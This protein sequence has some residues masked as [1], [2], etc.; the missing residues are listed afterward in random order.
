MTHFLRRLLPRVGSALRAGPG[1][2]RCVA[3]AAL[4]ASCSTTPPPVEVGSLAD[5]PPRY[6]IVVIIHG[7]A[8]YAYHDTLGKVHRS[9]QEILSRARTVGERNAEAEVFIFHQI[10]RRHLLFLIPRRDGRAYVYR[11]GRLVARQSYW[12]DQGASPFDPEVRLYHQLAGTAASPP[13]RQFFYF[14]HELPEI[15]GTGY[16]ASYRKRPVTIDDLAEAVKSIAGNG[17]KIDLLGLAT[18]FG[19]TPHTIRALAPHA[20]YIV[21]SPDNLHLSS[22]DLTPLESLELESDDGAVA[23]FADRFARNAFER[24]ASEVQTVVSV[25]VYDTEDTWAFLDAVTGEYDRTLASTLGRSRSS[26]H[27]CDCADDSAYVLPGMSQGLT[28]LY[29]APRFGRLKGKVG[30]SGWECRRIL[31]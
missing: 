23:A 19:G 25:V 18:C 16:D 9:D 30:H 15:D 2:A 26:S 20:R 27:R 7:D 13:V 22:F 8:D 29:R 10:K 6:S 28:V 17:T 1:Y 3:L 21:A 14:G 31:E 12:R 24:L 11:N 5:P 4:L